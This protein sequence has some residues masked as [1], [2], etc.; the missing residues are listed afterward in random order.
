MQCACGMDMQGYD[1]THE[2]VKL[3]RYWICSKPQ[4]AGFRWNS[5][6]GCGRVQW[7]HQDRV[8]KA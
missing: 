8:E 3:A 6:A 2:G 1:V 4:P 7:E 5:T